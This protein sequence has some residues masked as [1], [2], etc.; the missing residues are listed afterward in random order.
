MLIGNTLD[1]EKFQDMVKSVLKNR[2]QAAEKRTTNACK[3]IQ[4]WQ[5]SSTPHK[6]SQVK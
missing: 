6:W 5:K 4:G 1:T 3:L 2:E